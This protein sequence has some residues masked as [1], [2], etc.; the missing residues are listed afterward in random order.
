MGLISPGGGFHLQYVNYHFTP[1][2]IIVTLPENQNSILCKGGHLSQG[3][4]SL[5]L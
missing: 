3:G 4:F 2:M 1:T 5:L